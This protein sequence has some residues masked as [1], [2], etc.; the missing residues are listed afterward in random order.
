[1]SFFLAV[2]ITSTVRYKSSSFKFS[3][4]STHT[5]YIK[6]I[7]QKQLRLMNRRV[8]KNCLRFLALNIK[9]INKINKKLLITFLVN[10]EK[11]GGGILLFFLQCKS[12][13]PVLSCYEEG[14][15]GS[16][17]NKKCLWYNNRNIKTQRTFKTKLPLQ[18]CM[19]G[20]TIMTS[21]LMGR[22]DVNKLNSRPFVNEIAN[23]GLLISLFTSF[24]LVFLLVNWISTN[25][26]KMIV[27][28]FIQNWRDKLVLMVLYVFIHL[29]IFYYWKKYLNKN[30]CTKKKKII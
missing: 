9:D 19:N 28:P 14:W 21:Q 25:W 17:T 24:L 6:V 16:P 23:N 1:M 2:L 30:R 10:N 11:K 20:L 7:N 22:N 13:L 5:L 8:K 18:F 12:L 3:R 29:L 15:R 27:R 4:S 26:L